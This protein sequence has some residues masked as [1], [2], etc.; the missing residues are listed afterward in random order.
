M[1]AT[2]TNVSEW[3]EQLFETYRDVRFFGSLDGLRFICI[4]LV[5]WH[6]GPLK[7]VFQD[8]HPIINRGFV[9]VD[10]FFV[11]SGFLITT[12][13]LRE[14]VTKGRFSLRAFYW[15]RI[16]RIIPIYFFVVTVIAL[17]EV[18]VKGN[19]QYFVILPYYYLFLSNFLVEHVPLLDP[20]WSLSVEEQYYMI[21]PLL[22][23]L[24]PRRWVAGI[25]VA[26]VVINVLGVMGAFAPLGITAIK[27]GLL[28]FQLP[29][30]TYA[31][32]LLGSLGAMVL[33]SRIGFVTVAP[34]LAQRASPVCLFA[35][36]IAVMFAMP[37]DQRG[38]PNLIMH[39]LMTLILMTLVMREDHALRTALSWQPV[40]RIGQ[41]SYGIYLYHLI[42]LVIL[43]KI[44][45]VV[46]FQWHPALL[47]VFYIGLSV[48]ISEI[49]FRTLE[50]YF[51]RFREK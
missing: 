7:A 40:V 29:N 9:G 45:S 2:Q 42:A 34:A 8:I 32:I 10:F 21:W 22:L 25:L 35:V 43:I 11:L 44:G 5:L 38:L 41:I 13:L 47:F 36:W 39:L 19:T 50:R 16:L 49:S 12:L 4:C 6:H 30:A 18:G 3:G 31:P 14:E 51:L 26:L 17:Y 20:T 33:H 48:L 28:S 27:T 37:A 15:R 1:Q 46:G 23:M 24:A